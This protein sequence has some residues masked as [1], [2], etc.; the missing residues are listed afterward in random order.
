MQS[1]QICAGECVTGTLP[2]HSWPSESLSLTGSLVPRF[3][4]I[5]CCLKLLHSMLS[6][7]RESQAHWSE[8]ESPCAVFHLRMASD[9][10]LDDCFTGFHWASNE[11][12]QRWMQ[13][14]ITHEHCMH[15]LSSLGSIL[16]RGNAMSLN[17]SNV[18]GY[19]WVI[20]SWNLPTAR[21]SRAWTLHSHSIQS[22]GHTT[23]QMGLTDQQ[24]RQTL[25]TD[26]PDHW[27]D[28]SVTLSFTDFTDVSNSVISTLFMFQCAFS[29]I[30][31][32]ST[33]CTVC[34]PS[35]MDCL[36]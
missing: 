3:H 34:N 9:I 7:C 23:I 29:F 11:V 24:D 5:Q 2:H 4:M 17:N 6:Y 32:H 14:C 36:K 19:L 18:T 10:D 16:G 12:I 28:M 15:P 33:H 27:N 20:W 13:S 35:F 30:L 22:F 31:F 1:C 21:H 26:R 8:G 25:S